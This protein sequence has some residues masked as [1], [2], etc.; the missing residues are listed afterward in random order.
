MNGRL[1]NLIV[2]VGQLGVP[3]RGKRD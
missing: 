2:S 3:W 1:Y